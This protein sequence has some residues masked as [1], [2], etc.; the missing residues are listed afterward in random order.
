MKLYKITGSLKDD[1]EF[2]ATRWVGSQADAASARKEF[3]S[4]LGMPRD[5]ITTEE[6]EVPTTKKELIEF[7][8]GLG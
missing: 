8:N 7:L 6:V 1:N 3:N 2:R 4:K 5:R